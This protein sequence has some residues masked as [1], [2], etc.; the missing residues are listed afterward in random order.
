MHQQSHRG[1]NLGQ[2]IQKI[3]MQI[4]ALGLL[5]AGKR[6]S[7]VVGNLQAKQKKT[8][9]RDWIAVFF[10]EKMNGKLLWLFTDACIIKKFY[11]VKILLFKTR[12]CIMLPY[13]VKNQPYT[14]KK[15]AKL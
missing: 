10:A 9:R 14:V 5:S 7:Y 4:C 3:H 8:C 6:C 2:S 1:L 12:C 15:E 13:N 11:T